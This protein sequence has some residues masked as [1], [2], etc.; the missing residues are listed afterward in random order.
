MP[1]GAFRPIRKQRP[2]SALVGRQA[3]DVPTVAPVRALCYP[4]AVIHRAALLVGRPLP[5]RCG[6]CWLMLVA[7]AVGCCWLPLAATGYCWLLAAAGCGWLLLAVAGC[8]LL[9]AASCY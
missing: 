2:L 3:L 1:G 6:N 9:L 5:A 7:A 4:C 8:W